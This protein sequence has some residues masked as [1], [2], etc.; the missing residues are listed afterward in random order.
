M[1]SRHY[2][3]DTADTNN[4]ANIFGFRTDLGIGQ[5]EYNLISTIFFI[6]SGPQ[7]TQLTLESALTPSH[8][9][10]LKSRRKSP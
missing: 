2:N 10:Y 6:V 8:T 9:V 5:T 3:V 1:V 4:S 7:P